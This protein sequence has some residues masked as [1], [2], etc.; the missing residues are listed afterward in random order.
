MSRFLQW[1]LVVSLAT[2]AGGLQGWAQPFP[3]DIQRIVTARKIRV[4]MLAPDIPPFIMTGADGRLHGFDV[5]LARNLAREFGVKLELVRTATTFNGIVQQ[6]AE[7]HADLG[8]SLLTISPDRLQLVYFSTPYLTMHMALLVN[9]RERLLWEKKF[10]RQ[11]LRNTT[12]SIGVLKGSAY[13]LTAQQSF[14]RATL[15]KYDSIADELAAVQKGE[16]LG[17]LDDDIV[18]KGFLKTHPGAA[19]NLNVQVFEDLPD[20]VGIAV[21]PDSPHLLAWI[22]SYLLTQGLHLTSSEILKKFGPKA[23][24]VKATG[25]EPRK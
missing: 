12:A 24:P 16:I 13:I 3:K 15:K 1:V 23:P 2:L 8:I 21:R 14:P 11:A 19:V 7:K 4:A 25:K 10:P 6:V 18:I 20:Y 17:M 9:R 5:E 22:N